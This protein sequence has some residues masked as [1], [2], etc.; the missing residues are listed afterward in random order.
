MAIPRFLQ[1]LAKQ[2]LV[3][4]TPV[5]LEQLAQSKLHKEETTALEMKVVQ[6]EE[7]IIKLEERL[8]LLESASVWQQS[9][10]RKILM[11]LAMYML[12]LI[13]FTVMRMVNPWLYAFIPA[14]GLFMFL[15]I[16]T[17]SQN[18]W[19]KKHPHT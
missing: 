12:S 15:L 13:V 5:V 11:S 19:L 4:G 10:L 6:L 18:L 8:A 17:Y 7:R 1:T 2:L 9:I 3:Q 14:G 16:L